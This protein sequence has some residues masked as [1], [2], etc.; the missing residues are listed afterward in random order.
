M[1]ERS[2]R[3]NPPV[4]SWLREC[5]TPVKSFEGFGFEGRMWDLIVSVPD[6]CLSFTLVFFAISKQIPV[7]YSAD[8]GRAEII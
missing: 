5:W 1:E 4:Q 7:V 2:E 6:H 8:P 3:N